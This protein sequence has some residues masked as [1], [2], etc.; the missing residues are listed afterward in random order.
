M[1]RDGKR[2]KCELVGHGNEKKNKEHTEGLGE[3]LRET[4]KKDG[5]RNKRGT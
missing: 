4:W 3:A 5:M 2:G 1:G